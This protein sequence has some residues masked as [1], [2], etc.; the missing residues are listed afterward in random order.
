MALGSSAPTGTSSS[1]SAIV[2]LPDGDLAE[3]ARQV[4]DEQL[5]ATSLAEQG[6]KLQD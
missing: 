2:T 4:L 5:G 3:A 1:T 6:V